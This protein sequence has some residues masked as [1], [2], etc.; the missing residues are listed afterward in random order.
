MVA[1]FA[2]LRLIPGDPAR[3]IAGSNVGPAELEQIRQGLGLNDPI[4]TQ[5][6]DYVVGVFTGDLGT[7]YSSQQPVSTII[8]DRLPKTLELAG[9][10]FVLAVGIGIPLGLLVGALTRDGLRP[11]LSAAFTGTTSFVQS[12]PDYLLA[13]LLVLLFAVLIPVFPV[14]GASGVISLVLPA[15]AVAAGAAAILA[16]VTRVE[17]LAVLS[18]DYVRAARVKQLSTRRIY[19]VHVLPNVMTSALTISGL[20]LTALVGGTVVVEN[21]FAWPGL[22]TE[23]VRAISQ[24]DYPVVQAIVLMLG[25]TIVIVNLLVDVLISALDPRSLLRAS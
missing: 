14:A 15:T 3:R 18:A 20:I 8:A 11:R 1:S 22:G 5:L 6:K 7:S 13:A 9:A 4:L 23:L 19:G 21:V 16:R 2:M 17:T 10:G 25:V 12:I 24:R